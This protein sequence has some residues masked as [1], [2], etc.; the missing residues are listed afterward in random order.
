M[1]QSGEKEQ[2]KKK[3]SEVKTFSVPFPLGE[4]KENITVNINTPSKASKE[5]IINQAIQ[6]HSQGNIQEA[7]KY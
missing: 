5:Q 6:F 4:I 2:E 1:K 3:V 7:A